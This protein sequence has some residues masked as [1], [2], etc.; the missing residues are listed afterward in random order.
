MTPGWWSWTPGRRA[1]SPTA[2]GGTCSTPPEWAWL[3][4][5]LAE[6]G[7]HLLLGSSLPVLLPRAAHHAE[8]FSEAVCAGAWG[9]LAARAGEVV[10]R[11]VDL[12]HWA[13]FGD[14]FRR[15]LR[16]VRETATGPGAPACVT[17]LSGDVHHGYLARAR[18]ERPV[19]APVWQAV[20]SPMRNAVDGASR[21]GFAAAD[22]PG[23]S[24][25]MR[26]LAGLAG[27]PP[28]EVD[29]RVT[30]GPVFDNHVA[31]LELSGSRAELTLEVAAGDPGSG[32]PPGLRPALSQTLAGG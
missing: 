7:Q 23:W 17:M 16:L 13:A 4:D 5:Q 1:P 12:E 21:R 29:W 8:A 19:H 20:A 3:E 18:W 25:S 14:S 24:G 15:L 10:R 11:A 2:A 26:R 9:G 31:T 22:G 6:P 27:A 28:P 30:H 32:Q